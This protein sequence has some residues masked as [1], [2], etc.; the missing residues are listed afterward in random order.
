M[1][2]PPYQRHKVPMTH[3][4][5]VKCCAMLSLVFVLALALSLFVFGPIAY[6]REAWLTYLDTWLFRI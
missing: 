1:G 2:C 4:A 5:I 3:L 6:G